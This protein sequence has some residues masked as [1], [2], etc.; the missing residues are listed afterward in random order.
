LYGSNRNNVLSWNIEISLMTMSDLHSILNRNI[1]YYKRLSQEGKEKFQSRVTEFINAKEFES[2]GQL[3]LTDEKKIL[4]AA[5]AIQVTFGLDQYLF[6]HFET[7]ILYPEKFYSPHSKSRNVGEVNLSGIIVLSWKAFKTGIENPGDTYNVG[8][9]EMAHALNFSDLMDKDIDEGFSAY[10]HKWLVHARKLMK[11][12]SLRE[13]IFFRNYAWRNIKEFFAV[14]IEYFFEAPHQFKS[15][16]P[17]LFKHYCY[18][19]N[20]DPTRENYQMVYETVNENNFDRENSKTPI[21]S[22]ALNMPENKHMALFYFILGSSFFGF[23]AY[24]NNSSFIIMLLIGLVFFFQFVLRYLWSYKNRLQLLIYNNILTLKYPHK[25]FKKD[26]HYKWDNIVSVNYLEED[27]KS[28][29]LTLYKEG[30]FTTDS[31]E[32]NLSF[33][34]LFPVFK[35]LFNDKEVPILHNGRSFIPRNAPVKENSFWSALFYKKP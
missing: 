11:D 25:F 17:V 22:L 10:Y 29:K 7:I 23:I 4:V 27:V 31:F 2:R 5:A 32:V 15:Y 16:F 1:S 21:L 26:Y 24:I 8:L 34:D 6:K 35:Y 30:K 20:Q 9:H 28:I 3:V 18:L 12:H 13:K 19:L 14:G 33:D